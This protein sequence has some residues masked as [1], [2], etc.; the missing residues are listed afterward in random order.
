V[1]RKIISIAS[2]LIRVSFKDKS[3]ILWLFV[4]PIIWTTLIGA[5]S[6]FGSSGSSKIPIAI[7]NSDK[8]I[9]GDIYE[10]VMKNEKDLD[11]ILYSEENF[12]DVVNMVKETKIASMIYIPENFSDSIINNSDVNITIYKSSSNNSFYIEELVKK[13]TNQIDISSLTGHFV[14]KNIEKTIILN[15]LDKKK[16][17]ESSF[18][19]ALKE[20]TLNN[21]V[22]VEYEIL[23]V[24]KENLI[25]PTGFN[26]TSPG[27]GVMF[28]MMGAFF[29]AVVLAEE[30]EMNILSRLL[31]TPITKIVVLSGK[32]LGVFC[33]TIIQ[34]LFIIF[35]GQFILG[36]NWGN[37][38][39]SVLL[40]AISFTL[41]AVG[42]GT[43][44]SSIVKTSAQASALTI[45]ISIV[46]SM[47]GGAWWPIEIMPKYLQ[48]IAKFTPQYWAINGFNKII[49][50]GFGLKEIMPNFSILIIYA[51]VSL[52]IASIFFRYE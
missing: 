49:L 44:L 34:F 35:F 9:Y 11:I 47:I 27:F 36:V 10:D 52:L 2:N 8:G 20:L 45:L 37:S 46:T 23:S 43:I 41:S 12:K 30:R 6:S 1:F 19:E 38:P 26:A 4:M 33:V 28:V 22:S 16:Y 50:R 48:N 17:F 5:V 29:T 39:L 15:D 18:N 31:T 40:I 14:L 32:L 21:K 7:I 51:I 3:S 24:Q 13:I 25:L 42:L